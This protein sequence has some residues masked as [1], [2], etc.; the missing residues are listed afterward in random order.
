MK[1]FGGVWVS[2]FACCVASGTA[3]A[4]T[5]VQ[6]FD[7]LAVGSSCGWDAGSGST[8]SSTVAYSGSNSCRLTINQGDT[9]FG[10]WGGIINHPSNVGRGGEIWLRLRTYMPAGFN[11]NSIGEGDHLKFLRIHT[12]SNSNSNFG[13]DDWYINPKGTSPPFLFIYEGEQ[14]W[15]NIG[16]PQNAIVLGTWETYEYYVHLD[17]VPAANGGMARVR[18]WKNGVLMAELNDRITLQTTDGY[19]D[20]THLFTYWNGG[21]PATQAMYV[22]DVELTTD[23]PAARDAQGNPYI[24]TGGGGGPPPTTP[25]PPVIISVH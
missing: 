4:W 7:N 21:S 23:T 5:I 16:T 14:V 24:G 3:E 6:N 25:M 2:L 10:T 1:K 9:A 19:S 11:Y 12:M 20:R 22:D 13:Y 18:A 15:D 8:V 17:T